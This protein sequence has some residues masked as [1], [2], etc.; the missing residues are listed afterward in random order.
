MVASICFQ[1]KSLKKLCNAP[2]VRPARVTI[3][4][5]I[6]QWNMGFGEKQLITNTVSGPTVTTLHYLCHNPVFF[7]FCQGFS[8]S[9]IVGIALPKRELPVVISQVIFVNC[10]CFFIH[11]Y[12]I[13]II[14]FVYPGYGVASRLFFWA[15]TRNKPTDYWKEHEISEI[16]DG[17]WRYLEERV[18]KYLNILYHVVYY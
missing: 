5:M 12:F 4:G 11:G 9:D 13:L 10:R 1:G 18:L 17:S 16:S 2:L 8:N 7:G 15:K 14:V 3:H 6:R